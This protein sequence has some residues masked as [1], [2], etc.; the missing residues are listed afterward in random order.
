MRRKDREIKEV[1]Q[2]EEIINRALVVRLALWDGAWPYLVTLCFGYRDGVLYFHSAREGKKIEILKK[3]NRAAFS[4]EGEMKMVKRDTPCRW[5]M[6]YES[7]VGYGEIS[8]LE[9]DD[10]KREALKIIMEHYGK[11]GAAFLEESL[12]QVAVL[13]LKIQ[14]M[15]G[16]KSP[17][18]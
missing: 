16:K 18:P 10:E 6:E 7:V 2:I 5:S 4:L 14:S 9:A 8:F 1:S 11:E 12:R 17:Q 13:A 15:S 3:M